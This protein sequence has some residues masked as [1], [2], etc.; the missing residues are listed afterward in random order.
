MYR[1]QNVAILFRPVVLMFKKY[2]V[3]VG[4]AW[5]QLNE[6][7]YHGKLI[8]AKTWGLFQYWYSS[9]PLQRGTIYHD[10]T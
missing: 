3:L 6:Y 9:V 10:I 8:V 1:L 2:V 7:N 5:F 4:T